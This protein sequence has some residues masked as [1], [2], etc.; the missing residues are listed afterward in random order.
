MN[1]FIRIFGDNGTSKE[2]KLKQSK[3]HEQQ[4]ERSQVGHIHYLTRYLNI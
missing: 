3:S 4:F 1:V 2:T